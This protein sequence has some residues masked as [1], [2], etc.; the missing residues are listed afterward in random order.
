MR[1]AV[2]FG[3]FLG[4][5]LSAGFAVSAQTDAAQVS[6]PPAC[7]V[8]AGPI[9]V[10]TVS[11]PV[12]PNSFA[13]PY[14]AVREFSREETLANGTVISQKTGT[15]KIYRDSQ[16]RERI[17]RAFCERGGN[18]QGGTLV[19]IRDPVSGNGYVLDPAA[20]TAHRYRRKVPQATS[21][22]SFIE[23]YALS[24]VAGA[25]PLVAGPPYSNTDAESLGSQTMEGLWV[26][27]VRY[28]TVF[29][30]GLTG[31]ERPS[32]I[33]HEAW[34]SPLLRVVILSKISY[35]RSGEF[36]SRLTSID[37]S[38]PDPALFQPPSDYAVIDETGPVT[39]M[40]P[41]PNAPEK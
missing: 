10:M 14:S 15:E 21:S 31:N 39:L 35:P 27:G 20:H 32:N 1:C 11:G 22:T 9:R 18:E 40:F 36:V 3:F 5:S 28:T 7:S 16:G 2:R 6:T 26:D 19:E 33:V 30:V 25:R 12:P 37:L 24:E 23:A 17:D 34:T 38:E 8:T 29:P 41:G 4:F 13:S